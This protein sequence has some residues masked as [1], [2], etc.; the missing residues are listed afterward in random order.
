MQFKSCKWQVRICYF[1]S[2]LMT[3]SFFVI[4][5]ICDIGFDFLSKL[6]CM[7]NRNQMKTSS[8][9][10]NMQSFCR[11]S[12]NVHQYLKYSQLITTYEMGEC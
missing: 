9:Q 7:Q 3:Y 8:L 11:T 4:N 1:D 10:R 6:K 12:F 5:I 2:T